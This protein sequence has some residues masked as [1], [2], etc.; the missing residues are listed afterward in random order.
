[1][2]KP[3]EI[4]QP[5]ITLKLIMAFL[6]A[7]QLGRLTAIWT[8]H[9]AEKAASPERKART[10]ARKTAEKMRPIIVDLKD[11]KWSLSFDERGAPSVCVNDSVYGALVL[12]VNNVGE[13]LIK[14]VFA[15]PHFNRIKADIDPDFLFGLVEQVNPKTTYQQEEPI[16]PSNTIIENLETF[17]SEKTAKRNIALSNLSN[18]P[19]KQLLQLRKHLNI[20]GNGNGKQGVVSTKTA[21]AQ[22]LLFMDERGNWDWEF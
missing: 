15:T 8:K 7:L 14:S 21:I 4:K 22:I 5:K 10:A 16:W 3:K 13:W 2:S 12:C 18:L 20:T 19:R 6:A 1:M 17:S 9:A 11:A